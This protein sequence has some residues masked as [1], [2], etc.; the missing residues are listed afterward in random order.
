M[1]TFADHLSKAV[2]AAVMFGILALGAMVFFITVGAI[3]AHGSGG[4]P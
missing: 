2:A 4:C 3:C 1:D